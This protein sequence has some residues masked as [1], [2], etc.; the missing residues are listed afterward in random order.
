M[1]GKRYVCRS[2]QGEELE[3]LMQSVYHANIY[4]CVCVCA[5]ACVCNGIKQMSH[6][7]IHVFKI[8]NFQNKRHKSKEMQKQKNKKCKLSYIF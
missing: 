6:V 1:Y 4:V 5:R 7:F 8:K 2:T 3:P